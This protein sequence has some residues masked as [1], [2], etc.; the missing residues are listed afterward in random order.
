MR[1][2]TL[3]F[4]CSQGRSPGQTFMLTATPEAT[5]NG[6]A[7][8]IA[9]PILPSPTE[10]QSYLMPGQSITDTV[11]DVSGPHIDVV[12]FTSTLDGET[13][14]ITFQLRDVPPNVTFNIDRCPHGELEYRWAVAVDV[15]NDIQTGGGCSGAWAGDSSCGA[16]YLLS[17]DRW[18]SRSQ[19]PT[20]APLEEAL[21]FNVWELDTAG[22]QAFGPASI[23][24]DSE[25]NTITL[26]G[27]IPGIST[28]SRLS[29]ETCDCAISRCDRPG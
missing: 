8:P 22:G 20:V 17:A 9:T 23:A 16:E 26:S 4:R 14:E 2:Y 28:D 11:S 3:G 24:V 18:S 1:Y 15:D 6:T 21:Q 7:T 19:T 25:A 29:F 13:L 10:T 12:G 5:H 27:I